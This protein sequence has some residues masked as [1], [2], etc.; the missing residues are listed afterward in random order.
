MLQSC[1]AIHQGNSGGALV[2]A[3]SGRLLGLITSNARH[4][5]GHII[6][7]LNFTLPVNRLSAIC[8]F[9]HGI[10]DA[11]EAINATADAEFSHIWNLEP[12]PFDI[13]RPSEFDVDILHAK[14]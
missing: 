2:C 10:P 7:T 6:P 13:I 9:L 12:P 14:L 11:L 8:R 5:S 4:I 3:R 1:V